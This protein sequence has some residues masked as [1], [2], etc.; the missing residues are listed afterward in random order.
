MCMYCIYWN[1]GRGFSVNLVL[2]FVEV[3]LNLHV[4]HQTRSLGTESYRA[5]PGPALPNRHVRYAF[6]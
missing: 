3:V 6:F 1:E 2:K 5:K 4:K